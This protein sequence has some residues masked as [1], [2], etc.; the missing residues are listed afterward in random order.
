[1]T[2]PRA[3]KS[4]PATLAEIERALAEAERDLAALHEKAAELAGAP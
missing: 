1:M 4:E 2:L 3:D